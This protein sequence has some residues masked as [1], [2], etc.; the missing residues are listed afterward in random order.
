MSKKNQPFEKKNKFTS[1]SKIH[2]QAPNDIILAQKKTN[3]F[4]YS[5]YNRNLRRHNKQIKQ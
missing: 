5:L 2:Y 4:I 1:V 3:S